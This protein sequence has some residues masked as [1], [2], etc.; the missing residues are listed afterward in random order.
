LG[1]IRAEDI[2]KKEKLDHEIEELKQVA[3]QK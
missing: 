2:K 3:F 1:D